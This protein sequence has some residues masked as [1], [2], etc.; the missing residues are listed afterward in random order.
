MTR[1]GTKVSP[2]PNEKRNR[3]ARRDEAD[4]HAD[5]AGLRGAVHL[6]A[7]RARAAIDQRNLAAGIGEIGILRAARVDAVGGATLTDKRDVAG[8]ARTDRRP[9]DRRRIGIRAGDRS[10]R[11]DDQR[12][13]PA[14]SAPGFARR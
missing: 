5:R 11:I 14:R 8:E 6:Q 7:D 13:S 12:E 2:P 3:I 1:V 9:L 10:R 4:E